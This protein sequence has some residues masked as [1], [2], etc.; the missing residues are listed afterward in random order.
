MSGRRS[1][2]AVAAAR[3]LA[4]KGTPRDVRMVA[5]SCLV[6]IGETGRNLHALAMDARLRKLSRELR[7][8][9]DG[10]DDLLG[11]TNRDND[12]HHEGSVWE[13]LR[14][15]QRRRLAAAVAHIKRTGTL[16]RSDIMGFGKVSVPQAANDIVEIRRRLPGLMSLARRIPLALAN[17]GMRALSF[18]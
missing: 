10:I 6:Q 1:N 8:M 16:N 12:E 11:V 5:A 9:A 4:D 15:P 14:L 3:L 18:V 17:G 13:G 7:A 2:A